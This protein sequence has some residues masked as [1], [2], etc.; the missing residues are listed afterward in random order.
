[1]RSRTLSI[2]IPTHNKCRSLMRTLASLERIDPADTEFEVIV[3]DD[4]SNDETDRWLG[5][6]RPGPR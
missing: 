6:Y 3:V 1:M 4:A 5:S 2:V